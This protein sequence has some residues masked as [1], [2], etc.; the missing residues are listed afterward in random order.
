MS[1]SQKCHK[2]IYIEEKSYKY[3]QCASG[4]SVDSEKCLYSHLL[5]PVRTLLICRQQ[6][7]RCICCHGTQHGTTSLS[8]ASHSC[9]LNK[10]V[11]PL[12]T[13]PSLLLTSHHSQGLL[14]PINPLTWHLK[15]GVICPGFCLPLL[16]NMKKWF[17]LPLWLMQYCFCYINKFTI[18]K[19]SVSKLLDALTGMNAFTS[20]CRKELTQE[21]HTIHVIFWWRLNI[22]VVSRDH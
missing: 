5:D 14:L 11:F 4:A 17:L 15:L 22:I 1:L 6:H 3:K 12:P 19:I 9:A 16:T 21:K 8:H 2:R 10:R 13:D 20:K 18:K 7:F